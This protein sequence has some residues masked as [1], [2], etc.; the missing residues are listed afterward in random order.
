MVQVKTVAVGLFKSSKLDF[1]DEAAAGP[2]LEYENALP[3]RLA[4]GAS[5]LKIQDVR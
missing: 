3:Y 5:G 4:C 2:T 1:Q